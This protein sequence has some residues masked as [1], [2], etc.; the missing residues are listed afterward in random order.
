LDVIEPETGAA[1]AASA[2]SVD[3]GR[4]AADCGE[5]VPLGIDNLFFCDS[6]NVM[7]FCSYPEHCY[8]L[9]L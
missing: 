5:G 8:S 3:I 2:A 1:E 7:V 4:G 6:E 9:F